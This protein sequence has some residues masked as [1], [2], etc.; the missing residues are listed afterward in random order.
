[1]R[2]VAG[3]YKGR[4]FDVPRTFKARPT[5]DFA[6]ENLFNVLQRYLDFE[7][8]PSALDLF[9]GTGSITLEFLSRGCGRVVS[10][11]KEALHYSFIQRFVEQL[12]DLAAVPVRGDVFRFLERCNEK[13]DI[14]FA[15]PPYQLPRLCELPDLVMGKD[16][17]K[18]NGL[19][20]LEHGKDQKFE[21]HPCF[22]EHRAYGSVNFTFF[23]QPILS[24]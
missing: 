15:D 6:K 7:E 10:V 20:V 13:F 1:M 11:E 19:F 3:K 14:V 24:R 17:L 23:Q 12:Q 18:E 16:I 5:T 8:E 22:V 21:E 9:A 2:V 4:H